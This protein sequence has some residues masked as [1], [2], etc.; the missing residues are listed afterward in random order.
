MDSRLW[1]AHYDLGRIHE[2][3]GDCGKAASE[4]E[5]AVAL[6]RGNHRPVA[7]L[8]RV[9]ALGGRQAEARETLHEL[10]RRPS[11]KYVSS[12]GLAMIHFS[13]GEIDKAFSKLERA[14]E[15]NDGEIIF[16]GVDRRMDDHR[17]DRRY[18]SLVDR[19]NFSVVAH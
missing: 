1:S 4:L 13:L 7:A 9:Q 19:L 2:L 18:Q 15:R 3:R 16:I 14:Y 11:E 8:G 10:E 5:K 12:Y 17:L 6:S